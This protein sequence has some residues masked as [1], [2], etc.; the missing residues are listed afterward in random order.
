VN[1][2]FLREGHALED[3]DQ[4]SRRVI[5]AL[6]A[7][8]LRTLTTLYDFSDSPLLVMDPTSAELCKLASN[9]ALALRVSMANEVALTALAC[10]ADPDLVLQGIGADPRIGAGYLQ[11]GLGFGGYCLP[12]D[13]AAFSNVAEREPAT[14]S[15]VFR[16][17][18]AVNEQLVDRMTARVLDAIDGKPDG[19][20]ALSGVAFKAGS[21]S[22]RGSRGIELARRLHARG[23]R[24]GTTDA[25]VRWEQQHEFTGWARLWTSPAIAAEECD[26][27]LLLH[28]ADA[29]RLAGRH[30]VV[31]DA[32]GRIVQPSVAAK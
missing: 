1:P 10:G 6:D 11:P 23:I 5:G 3:F 30:A 24:V 4:P 32:L 9:A 15:S 14:S 8:T 2:E 18:G 28:P 19:L 22:I 13:L 29:G 31:L 17:A 27:L 16:A 7:K 25:G 20:V 26:V 21:D 12:K